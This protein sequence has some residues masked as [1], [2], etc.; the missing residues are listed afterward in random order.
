MDSELGN[1]LIITIITYGF[2]YYCEYYFN[3]ILKFDTSPS[4]SRKLLNKH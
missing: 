3:F 2:A 4:M 1:G